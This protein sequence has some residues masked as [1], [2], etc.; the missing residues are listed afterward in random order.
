MIEKT[1]QGPRVGSNNT[2][3]D[4]QQSEHTIDCHEYGV[5]EKMSQPRLGSKAFEGSAPCEYYNCEGG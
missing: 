5:S 1:A 2:I 3:D 4:H